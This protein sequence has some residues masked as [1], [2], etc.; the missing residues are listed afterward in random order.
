LL[1]RFASAC[2]VVQRELE[3][4]LKSLPRKEIAQKSLD[5]YGAIVVMDSYVESAQWINEIAPE[6]LEIF[7]SIPKSTIDRIRNAGSISMETIPLKR[8]EITLPAAT[9]SFL[10]EGRRAF[11]AS[12]VYHFQRR[13]G[14]IRYTK[15]E[16]SV[17]GDPLMRWRVLRVWM[18]TRDL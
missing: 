9:M 10:P 3:L 4:Q 16:L 17:P 7:S 6:H 1:Y 14:I 18:R 2:D 12:C 13:T 11:L 8:L 5:D 15:E